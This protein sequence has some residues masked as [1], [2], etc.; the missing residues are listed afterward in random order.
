MGGVFPY[1]SG[2]ILRSI[3]YNSFLADRV[4]NSYVLL[5]RMTYGSDRTDTNLNVSMDM[6]TFPLGV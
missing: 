2:T 5:D 3:R 6:Q 4:P 1:D